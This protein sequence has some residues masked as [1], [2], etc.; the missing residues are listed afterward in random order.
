MRNRRVQYIVLLVAAIA[1]GAIVAMQTAP[2]AQ[3]AGAPPGGPGSPPGAPPG[4]GPGGPPMGEP[5]MAGGP[6]M[7][8]PGMGMPGAAGGGTFEWK[9][10]EPPAE[11]TMTYAE[12][13]AQTGLPRADIPQPL[14]VKEDG[15]P[16]KYTKNA[17][18][19]LQRLYQ[20]TGVAVREEEMKPGRFGKG[21]DAKLS[22]M[23]A[24]Y[25]HVMKAIIESY[26]DA[27]REAFYFEVGYPQMKPPPLFSQRT[28][29]SAPQ[30]T[31]FP[32]S[33][34]IVPVVMRVK[35][36]A[37][38]KYPELVYRRLKKFDCLGQAHINNDVVQNTSA[39]FYIVTQQGGYYHPR[40]VHLPNEANHL[41]NVLW[42][43]TVI[44]LG[45]TDPDGKFLRYNTADTNLY[46]ENISTDVIP[47]KKLVPGIMTYDTPG[48]GKL[49][50]PAQVPQIVGYHIITNITAPEK[51]RD[52][53]FAAMVYPNIIYYRPRYRLVLWEEGRNLHGKTWKVSGTKGWIYEFEFNLERSELKRLHG[54]KV[55]L[56]PNFIIQSKEDF[57]LYLNWKEKEAK[58]ELI[59]R[60]AKKLIYEEKILKE[61]ASRTEYQYVPTTNQ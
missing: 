23:E 9:T 52:N 31:L 28:Q 25:W 46:I 43:N 29:S 40:I 26:I 20:T 27:L 60:L 38:A 30:K 5:G 2:L 1:V 8:G 47:E 58:N 33:T 14:L 17:W 42:K 48:G 57:E 18:H 45:L 61:G 37:Q 41:W 50:I 11:L 54:V 34:V 10:Y 6:G 15:T 53:I 19:Q 7:G 12:F 24:Y 51:L 36:N 44:G 21:M 32:M 35:P 56:I 4:G 59:R 3:E 16:A 39:P 49:M 13:L 55:H 22:R